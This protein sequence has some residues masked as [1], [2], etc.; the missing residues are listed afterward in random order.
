MADP[1]DACPALAALCVKGFRDLPKSPAMKRAREDPDAP[2]A[3][4]LGPPDASAPDAKRRRVHVM[5]VSVPASKALRVRV[6]TT[7]GPVEKTLRVSF[8]CI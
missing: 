7:S 5:T 8:E 1:S 3:L 2:P 4:D 6:L